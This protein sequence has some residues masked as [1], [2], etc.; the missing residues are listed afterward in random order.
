[1]KETTIA[2]LLRTAAGIGGFVCI[3]FACWYLAT[4]TFALV[5]PVQFPSPLDTY[6]SLVQI[7]KKGYAGGTLLTHVIES[8]RLVLLGFILAAATGIPLGLLMGR[9]ELAH[10]YLNAMFQMIRPIA[11]IAWIPL[12]IIW[13]G[14]GTVAKL[15]VI[16][17]AAFAPTLINTS[18]GARNISPLLFAAAKAHGATPRWILT[19]VVIPGALPSIFTGLRISIQA[20]WMVLVAAELV[21]SFV[22]LG[23]VMIIATRD[24]DPSMILIAMVCIALLGILFSLLLNVVEYLVIPW[25]Q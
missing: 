1:M 2:P 11:P 5:R 19:D 13:F 8:S 6:D 25:R 16:W 14:L 3:L 20:C 10:S 22:G 4:E 18:A 9:S 17:L 21:G 24:L 12:T 23:H 7:W 15:F